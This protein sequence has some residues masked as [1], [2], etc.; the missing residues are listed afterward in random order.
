MKSWVRLP[1]RSVSIPHVRKSM[2]G[3]PSVECKNMPL[4]LKAFQYPAAPDGVIWE[5]ECSWCGSTRA[6]WSTES[7]DWRKSKYPGT[8]A[9][10]IAA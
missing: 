8:D 5:I 6:H 4:V 9:H 2:G 7:R 10:A 3:C 1:L